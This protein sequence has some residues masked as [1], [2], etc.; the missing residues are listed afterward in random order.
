MLSLLLHG[1]AYVLKNRD[2]R[3]VVNA[4]YPLDPSRVKV[5][6]APDGGVYYEL[7]S[8]DL[9]GIPNETP[10]VV[11]PAREMIHDRWNCLFHALMGISP[12]YALS[13]RR[14][15]S[16]RDSIQQHDVLWQRAAGRRAC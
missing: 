11:V 15:A 16:A 2:E 3:G 13:G 8:N 1:N 6:V 7:Q 12:L 10:P 9:A 14:D 4:L 5:L